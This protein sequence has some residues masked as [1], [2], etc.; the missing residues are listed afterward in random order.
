MNLPFTSRTLYTCSHNN[1]NNNVFWHWKKEHWGWEF[2]IVFVI[3]GLVYLSTRR[4]GVLWEMWGGTSPA[5]RAVSIDVTDCHWS[6]HFGLS[7]TPL[8]RLC[9]L[10]ENAELSEGIYFTAC[11]FFSFFFDRVGDWKERETRAHA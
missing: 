2:T 10:N 7:N 8:S 3:L 9:V 5:K 4:G 6:R 1:N 11:F